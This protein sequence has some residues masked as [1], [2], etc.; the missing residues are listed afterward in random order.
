MHKYSP[1]DYDRV[2]VI[3]GGGLESQMIPMNKP[4]IANITAAERESF[5][6]ALREGQQWCT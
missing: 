3:S 2:I 1:S 6:R 4:Q 5:R